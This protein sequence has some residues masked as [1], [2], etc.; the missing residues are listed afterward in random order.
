MESAP[1]ARIM[2]CVG[3]NKLLVG[4]AL[5]T[6]VGACAVDA[7][8]E[9]DD[10]SEVSLLDGKS[11]T[12][13]STIRF[14]GEVE[15]SYSKRVLY[16]KSPKYRAVKFHAEA[17]TMLEVYVRSTQGDPMAWLVGPNLDI[18]GESD[19]ANEETNSNISIESLAQ[20]GDY[21]VLFRDKHYESHYFDVAPVQ[22]NAPANAPTFQQFEPVYEGHVTGKTLATTEVKAGTQM[23]YF[24]TMLLDRWKRENKNTG[25]QVNA[26]ALQVAGQ[27]MWFIRLYKPGQGMQGIAYCQT[28]QMIANVGGTGEL[29]DEG[30]Y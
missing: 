6:V 26:Y 7:G 14:M 23:P 17:G 22:L 28:G 15:L 3:L 18:V 19:D 10:L 24:P 29:I 11:D 5:L 13:L 30:E 4:A 1:V 16:T 8:E 25:A 12:P 20:T 27:T 9:T 2:K 21:F